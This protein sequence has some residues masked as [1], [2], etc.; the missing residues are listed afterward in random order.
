[1]AIAAPSSTEASR[2][3]SACVGMVIILGCHWTSMECNY[4]ETADASGVEQAILD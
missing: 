3:S 1:V 2:G 4:I